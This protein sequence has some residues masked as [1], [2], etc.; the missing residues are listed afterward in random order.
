MVIDRVVTVLNP[1]LFSRFFAVHHIF[2]CQCRAVNLPRGFGAPAGYGATD[3]LT[4]LS[5]RG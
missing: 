3:M 4:E 1:V 2:T 5:L